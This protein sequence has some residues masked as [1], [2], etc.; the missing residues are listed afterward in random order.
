MA[1]M[2]D[3]ATDRFGIG[4]LYSAKRFLAAASS[5]IMESG[6]LTIPSNQR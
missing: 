5:R 3:F 2:S 1:S 6:R 4:V